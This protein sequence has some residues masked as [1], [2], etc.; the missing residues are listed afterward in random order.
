MLKAAFYP[1]DTALR[2][3]CLLSRLWQEQ[4]TR[5]P[6]RPLSHPLDQFEKRTHLFA[7]TLLS[8]A[9]NLDVHVRI[10]DGPEAV[11]VADVDVARGDLQ[12]TQTFLLCW[13]VCAVSNP[14]TLLPFFER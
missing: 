11:P 3:R 4:T 6:V 12:R 13:K 8:V 5:F 1:A 10:V 9:L 7:E 2:K 14:P